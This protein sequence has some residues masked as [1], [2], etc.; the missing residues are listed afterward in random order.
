M[1]TILYTIIFIFISGSVFASGWTE[2]KIAR[3]LCYLSLLANDYQQTID[4]S[5]SDDYFETNKFLGR[6][7][8]RCNIN[9]YF[10][11]VAAIHMIGTYLLPEDYAKLWQFRYIYDHSKAI[12]NNDDIG[13]KQNIN[14]SYRI[15]YTIKF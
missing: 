14:V 3:E 8:D 12:A 13:L 11:S 1:K 6:N 15:Y 10:L 7:P 4:I 9:T 2:K 5:K